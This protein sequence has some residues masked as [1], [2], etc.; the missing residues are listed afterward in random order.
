ML[1]QVEEVIYRRL[2]IDP[3]WSQVP[4]V[5]TS[6]VDRRKDLEDDV[7]QELKVNI[8]EPIAEGKEEKRCS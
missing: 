1:H 4:Q 5:V 3:G 7:S 2:A 8:K 6:V